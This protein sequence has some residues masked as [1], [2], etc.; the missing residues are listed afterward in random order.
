MDN[1]AT[2]EA[3]CMV[4][5]SPPKARKT[6]HS[7][8]RTGTLAIKGRLQQP[9]ASSRRPAT[10]IWP[11]V[12]SSHRTQQFKKRIRIRNITTQ[13]QTMAMVFPDAAMASGMLQEMAFR[14]AASACSQ[15]NSRLTI[16]AA[17]M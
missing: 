3:V 12:G 15:R 4:T 16:Q 7:T 5:Q 13:P 8:N 6:E 2:A 14:Q 17:I 11:V 10:P 1:P 9:F